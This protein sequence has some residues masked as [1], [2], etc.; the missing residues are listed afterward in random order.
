MLF[1]A[2][3]QGNFEYHVVYGFTTAGQRGKLY[4]KIF[5]DFDFHILT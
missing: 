4:E 3:N 1:D 5:F 2:I